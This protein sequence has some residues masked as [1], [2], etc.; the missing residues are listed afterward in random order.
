M[1]SLQR[2]VDRAIA[3][4]NKAFL[5]DVAAVAASIEDGTRWLA[6]NDAREVVGRHGIVLP[7]ATAR[8]LLAALQGQPGPVGQLKDGAVLLGMLQAAIDST[9]K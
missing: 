1:S 7:V 9:T 2:E 3:A 5:A 8:E 6:I 4:E